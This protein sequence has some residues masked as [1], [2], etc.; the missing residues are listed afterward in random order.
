M[1]IGRSEGKRPMS[2][3]KIIE[4]EHA[5]NLRRDSA[6]NAKPPR[7]LQLVTASGDRLAIIGD[8]PWIVRGEREDLP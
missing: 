7:R 6:T 2:P 4:H 3:A 1:T 5:H 8:A